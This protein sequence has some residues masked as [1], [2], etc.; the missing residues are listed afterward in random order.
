[1]LRGAYDT[2]TLWNK[3]RNPGTNKDEWFRHVLSGC[4]WEHKAVRTV[5]GQTASLASV[6]TVLIPENILFM[7]QDEW[8]HMTGNR[9]AFFTVQTGDIIALGAHEAEITDIAPYRESDVIVL[10]AP[11]AF[12]VKIFQDNTAGYKRGRHY[13]AEGT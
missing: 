5:T 7:N 1:M 13:Y 9:T 8:E 12:K 11:K 6:T 4:S 3:W 10:Y 2:I